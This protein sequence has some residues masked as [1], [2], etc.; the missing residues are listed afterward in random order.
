[1]NLR[2]EEIHD[3]ASKVLKFALTESPVMQKTFG[4]T[5]LTPIEGG[6]RTH[7]KSAEAALT[8]LERCKGMQILKNDLENCCKMSLW[9]LS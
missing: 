9:S 8:Y 2:M 3:G 4:S 5:T 1:M 6:K 7:F